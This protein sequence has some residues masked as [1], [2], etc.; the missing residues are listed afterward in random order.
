MHVSLLT[1]RQPRRSVPRRG[2]GFT[3]DRGP[4]EAGCEHRRWEG[5]RP[6][7]QPPAGGLG[8]GPW[9]PLSDR[10]RVPYLFGPGE[11]IYVFFSTA[12]YSPC[13]NWKKKKKKSG[14]RL[15]PSASTTSREMLPLT[16]ASASVSICLQGRVGRRRDEKRGPGRLHQD[17]K[18]TVNNVIY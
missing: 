16:A 13:Q 8:L 11:K 4:R 12:L 14:P 17:V 1:R 2:R 15:V 18:L 9:P 7:L 3:G 5:S 10:K 6:T